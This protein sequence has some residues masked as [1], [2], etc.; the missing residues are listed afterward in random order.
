MKHIF[1]RTPECDVDGGDCPR[2]GQIC[3]NVHLLWNVLF[4]TPDTT[5]KSN[6][7]HESVCENQWERAMDL[8]FNAIDAQ[9]NIWRENCT[10]S[11]KFVDFNSDGHLNPRELTVIAGVATGGIMDKY[12]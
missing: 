4:A 2:G 3:Q 9:N 10:W 7:D 8:A 12:L 5:I 11:L 6:Y 1:G